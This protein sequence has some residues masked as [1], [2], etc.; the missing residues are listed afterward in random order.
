MKNKIIPL[1]PGEILVTEFLKPL[2]ISQLKLSQE[3]NVSLQT[4]NQIVLGKRGVT[5][6][7][8]LL[9]GKYF[10][11]SDDYWLKLQNRFDLEIAKDKLKSK[12]KSTRRMEL[13]TLVLGKGKKSS[14]KLT[15]EFLDIVAKNTKSMEEMLNQMKKSEQQKENRH[16]TTK[17]NEK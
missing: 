6:G 4:V 7:T 17:Q 9:F 12:L 1:H 14:G 15:K 16:E 3:I 5:A 2:N 11:L 8:S 13:E 10:G